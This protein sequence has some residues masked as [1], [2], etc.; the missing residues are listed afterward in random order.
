MDAAPATS[1][2]TPPAET[3]ARLFEAVHEGVYIGVIDSANNSTL[4]PGDLRKGDIP[5]AQTVDIGDGKQALLHEGVTVGDKTASVYSVPTS[6]G[7]A[8]LACFAE[9]DTCGTIASSMQI[10]DGTVFPVVEL[11][12]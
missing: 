8:T 9:G 7:V 1:T 10:T 4:L 3:F 12:H 2:S 5:E 6:A 11:C